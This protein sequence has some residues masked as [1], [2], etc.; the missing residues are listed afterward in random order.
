MTDTYS[1]EYRHQC[2]VRAIIEYRIRRGRSW[3]YN[4]LDGVEK[5]RGKAARERLEQDILRQWSLGN[6]GEPGLWLG[7][8]VA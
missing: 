3:A 1:E 2:E 8:P 7:P 4:F 6:R 5:Q